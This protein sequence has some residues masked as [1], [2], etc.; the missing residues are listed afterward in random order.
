MFQASFSI[1]KILAISTPSF[2]SSYQMMW[3]KTWAVQH[4]QR[5]DDVLLM[6]EILHH[7]GCIKPCKRWDKLPVNWCRISS[8]N[9]TILNLHVRCFL[10]SWVRDLQCFTNTSS[11]AA[12]AATCNRSP[13]LSRSH[14]YLQPRLVRVRKYGRGGRFVIR[15]WWIKP[16]ASKKNTR[17]FGNYRRNGEL[18]SWNV[19][20]IQPW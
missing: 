11:S 3:K 4:M 12:P 2:Q 16:A 20:F 13:L 17:G 19:K 5:N 9:S 1:G 10:G 18:D 6:E 14:A 15:F 7:L 8:I